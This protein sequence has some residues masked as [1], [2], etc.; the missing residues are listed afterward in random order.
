MHCQTASPTI[1]V[2]MAKCNITSTIGVMCGHT[3][4]DDISLGSCVATLHGVVSIPIAVKLGTPFYAHFYI[5]SQA[6][7]KAL[8]INMLSPV[9]L[10]IKSE[11]KK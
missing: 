9:L 2:T 5:F 4:A 8:T 10:K 7:L 6:L 3:A 11:Q 1:G